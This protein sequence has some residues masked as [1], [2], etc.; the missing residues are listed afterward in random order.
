MAAIAVQGVVN[1]YAGFSFCYFPAQ[2]FG[3][4]ARSADISSCTQLLARMLGINARI[5]DPAPTIMAAIAMCSAVIGA[6]R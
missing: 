4:A 6:K 5:S 3:N 2:R 1:C